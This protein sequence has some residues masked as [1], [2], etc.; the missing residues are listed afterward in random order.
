MST[1][2]D[3][4]TR[5]R[6]NEFTARRHVYE[7]H[8]V[9]LPP[10]VPYMRELWRR[11]EFAVELSRTNLR[12]QHFDTAFGQLWLILNPILLGFVYFLLVDILH[13]H[14]HAN[15]FFAHLLSGLFLYYFLQQSL[16]QGVKSV[17]TGGK[18]ILNSAFPRALLPLAAVRTAFLRF[19]PTMLI[20]IP[21]HIFT[22][23]PVTWQLLWVPAIILVLVFLSTG[24]TM[25]LAAGQVYFRDLDNFLPY[26][27]RI[28]LY[29]TPILYYAREVP[30]R[31]QWVLDANP[32]GKL[33]TAWSDVLIEGT[34]PTYRGIALG[35]AWGIGLFIVGFLFFM[36][37]ERE[38]AVRIA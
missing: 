6:E 16:T 10:I 12:A 31:Y 23:R 14:K 9:G 20:Y 3:V 36:S 13:H 34:A 18:L 37:R 7:P 27:L 26:V 35:A 15:Q 1:T 33:F 28:W 38:F 24:L 11:R 30:E 22:G 8:K 21:V 2:V 25:I 32:I 29:T 4:P 17:V 19:M 5:E